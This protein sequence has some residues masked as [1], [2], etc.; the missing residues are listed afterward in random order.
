M[1]QSVILCI[2]AAAVSTS[3]HA[4]PPQAYSG[5]WDLQCAEATMDIEVFAA[6]GTLGLAAD[7]RMSIQIPLSC[8]GASAADMA[9]FAYEGMQGCMDMLGDHGACAALVGDIR[10]SVVDFNGVLDSRIPQTMITRVAP[11]DELGPAAMKARHIYKSG[12]RRA[13]DYELDLQ[14]GEFRVGG[15]ALPQLDVSAI[16]A[17]GFS[18]DTYQSFSELK[19]HIDLETDLLASGAR[20]EPAAVCT[21]ETAASASLEV[22]ELYGHFHAAIQGDRV[23]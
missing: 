10:A 12:V 11:S 16:E 22:I 19:G 6:Q 2:A 17:M 23:Q 9:D 13:W 18:C 1:R 21:R 20:V 8:D 14:S 3:A 15:V 4:A 5:T 7:E